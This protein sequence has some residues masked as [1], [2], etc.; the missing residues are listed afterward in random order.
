MVSLVQLLSLT[1][2]TPTEP[3]EDAT[4]HT[5]D[6]IQE[7]SHQ[8]INVADSIISK[9]N[10]LKWQAIKEVMVLYVFR[11]FAN[12]GIL[13]RKTLSHVSSTV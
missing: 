7:L 11:E 2:D 8:F 10:T 4:N 12:L 6:N 3:F 9:E 5:Q 1:A 13:E